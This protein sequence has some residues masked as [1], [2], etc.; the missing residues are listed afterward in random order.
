MS[1][2]DPTRVG[3][4]RVEDAA[5]DI[6]LAAILAPAPRRVDEVELALGIA[7]EAQ[8]L[9]GRL[10]QF[11]TQRVVDVN[12]GLEY[13]EP[14][15]CSPEDVRASD[16]MRCSQRPAQSARNPLCESCEEI[17]LAL[18]DFDDGLEEVA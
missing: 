6:P 13:D 2:E 3:V 1:I 10:V 16:C 12:T 5:A 14:V 15:Y 9:A 18:A 7:L 8:A 11:G 4:A 17:H